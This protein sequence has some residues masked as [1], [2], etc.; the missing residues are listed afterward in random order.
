M[1]I[2]RLI[3]SSVRHFIPQMR[4]FLAG[5]VLAV[6][7]LAL[8]VSTY[9]A[10][11]LAGENQRPKVIMVVVNRVTVDDITNTRF[12][13]IRRLMEMGGLGLMTINSGGEITDN[14]SYV[15]L[16]GGDKFIGSALAGQSFNRKEVLN[17][18][19]EA[20]QA[21][22]RNTGID[23]GDSQVLNISIATT[24]MANQKRYTMSIPG[25]LG[26]IL[27]KAGLKTAV[28]GNS[29]LT[30][31]DEPDRWAATISMDEW[32]RVDEGNVSQD[33]LV[34]DSRSPYGWRTDYAKVLAE[35]DRMM[36]R[37][38][39]IVVET[40]DTI[41][42]NESSD[43]QTK[44]M[45]E[46]HR[47]RALDEVDGFIGTL[48]PRLSKDTMVMLVTPLPQAQALRDGTRLTPL[49]IAGGGIMQGS[50][51]TSLST[52]QKGLVV[53]YDVTAT[54]VDQLKAK[55]TEGIIG[56]PIL[57]QEVTGQTAYVQGMNKWLTANSLQRVGVLYYFTRYQGIVYLLI[58]LQIILKYYKKVV[59]VRFLLV[60][61]LLYP[62]VIL[63]LPLTGSL[64]PWLTIAQSLIILA[65]FTYLGTRIRDD[66]KMFVAIACANILPSVVDV[67]TGGYLMKR[68]ALSYDLVVGGRFYGIGNEYMGVV[69]GSVILGSA[70]LL[71]LAPQKRRWLL[72]AIGLFFA[73]II[74]FFAAPTIGTKAGGALTATVGFVVAANRYA[75][76]KIS[77]RSGFLVLGALVAGV[78]VLGTFNYLFPTG[79]QSHIG[80][81]FS[82]LLG[83]NFFAIWQ[84]ILR[85]VTANFYLLQHSPFSIILLL[86]VMVL[87]GL[88]F[89]NRMYINE[90][91]EKMPFM[92]AGFFGMFCG[93]IAAILLNDSG[94]IGAPLLLNY[95]I[96]PMVLL[97][98]RTVSTKA[99]TS[100]L[101]KWNWLIK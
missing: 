46:F 50:V 69:I 52:R 99:T 92:Q 78:T 35:L 22:W 55:P 3:T 95:L 79:E 80:R 81:A 38:D 61:L 76:R 16:G 32:G 23:P 68:A 93:A 62:L 65:L 70:A 45:A 63:V 84:I 43:R 86:Q 96:A 9:S 44:N 73:G 51:L 82:N 26:A 59:P 1:G 29:D 71:Q 47:N 36:G 33:L 6:F 39:F 20:W 15:S 14:N 41:R 27:H 89:G 34:K 40:G 101:A 49:V 53:N 10:P 58:F 19:S 28:I 75:G 42:A 87:G 24:L 21:Y 25:Q 72:P 60:A 94:V 2:H 100:N 7:V 85:K 4:R 17:D 64:N 31:N 67:I 5:A 88:F 57:G 18:G 12:K 90:L 98:F 54:V 83:G 30:P 11:V 77:L 8:I 13:N 66:L 74:I 91:C 97:L 37:A 48:I 56:I